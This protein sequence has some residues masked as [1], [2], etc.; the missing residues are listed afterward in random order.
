MKT[1]FIAPTPLTIHA[2]APMRVCDNGGW[3]DTWFAEFGRIFSIAVSPYAEVRIGVQ[4]R[5]SQ[6]GP[7]TLRVPNYDEEY[8]F[9]P[10][11]QPWGRHPLLEA[12]IAKMEVSE[13][14]TYHITVRTDAPPGM[15]TG[16]SAAV[17]VALIG[18][19]DKLQAGNMTPQK[20]A[21]AAHEVETHML[22]LQSGIQDQ[23][24]SAYGGINYIEMDNY[25][26]ARVSPLIL[27]E[28]LFAELEQRLAVIFLG[29]AH[30]SSAVHEKVIGQLKQA[31]PNDARLVALRKT[32]ARSR[33]AVLRGDWPTLGEA[34]IDNTE[35][36]S[37]LHPD[38]INAASRGVID[39][40]QR[41]G[42][43]GWKVNG[44]GGDGGSITILSRPDRE[45]RSAMLQH[46]E[47][48]NPLM[49]VIPIRLDREGLLCSAL[50]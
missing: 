48:A 1:D 5:T 37:Q 14:F 46:I 29:K 44:A 4:Q 15:G 11:R 26:D 28:E 49:Q 13:D 8:T 30:R 36:Q 21:Y 22:G 7:I 20:I 12:A 9:A 2:R 24:A 10:G 31:G 17:T 33:D 16:T 42:A 45:E 41:F 50:E 6:A 25:P 3:T 32:A 23:L 34:M 47:E 39:L 40:A 43:L 18:A 35:A 38:L 27:P 19:L